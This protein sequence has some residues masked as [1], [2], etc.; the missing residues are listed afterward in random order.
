[1]TR[2]VYSDML[3]M[4]G[5]AEW[6]VRTRAVCWR[7]FEGMRQRRS[8]VL[9]REARVDGAWTGYREKKGR[10]EKREAEGEFIYIICS[11]SGS[12]SRT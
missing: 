1:M 4:E 10:K 12:L 6:R 2:V 11:T 7:G 3:K 8:E 5:A 9:I